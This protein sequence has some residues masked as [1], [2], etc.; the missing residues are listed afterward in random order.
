MRIAQVTPR[1][2]PR[3]GGVETHVAAVA[4]RLVERGHDVVAVTAD[5]GPDVPKRTVRN[6]VTI[7]RCRGL[8]PGGNF[9]LGPG[10]AAVVAR[11]SFD[12]VHAHNY[13]AL[14]LPFAALGAASVRFVVTPHYHDGSADDRRDR[15]LSL[16]RP[17]G[18]LLLRNADT[19]IAVS[20]WER[21]RLADAFEVDA[22]VVRNGIDVERFRD[23]VPV[24]RPRPYLLTVGRLEAYKG[25]QYA[26]R[27]L[28]NLPQYDLVVA[29]TGDY[30]T[31]LAQVAR[32]AGVTERV[33]FVGYVDDETLPGLYAGATALL[34]LSEY[35]AFGMTVGEALA[36][37]TPCVVRG[38]SALADWTR[39]EGV[40]EAR[41]MSPGAVAGAVVEVAGTTP[42]AK[43]PTWDEAV[44]RLESAYTE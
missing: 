20:D 21:R 7:R 42:S 32:D 17:F 13:H 36:A 40:V 38:V 11:G 35:E 39:Y 12:V 25:V 19:V 44:D 15:L 23:A 16:Y 3:S 1:Y 5:A 30:R 33:T 31:S 4:E 34:A 26:I 6:G 10:V 18:S 28:S 22:T 24:N 8:A 14:V 9:H 29:G 37:G 27:A 43:L 41:D 2:P